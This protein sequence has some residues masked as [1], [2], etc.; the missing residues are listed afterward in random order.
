MDILYEWLRS[1]GTLWTSPFYYL[2]L[3]YIALHVRKQT[4]IERKLF[5]VKLHSWWSEWWRTL[6]WGA[7]VGAGVSV[8]F[9]F[10]GA[11]LTVPTLVML[12]VLAVLLS[13]FRV[14]YFCFAYAAG[15]LGLLQVA[16]GGLDGA[17][18]PEGVAMFARELDA[19]HMPSVLALVGVLH[20]AEAALVYK[21][22]GRLATPLFFEGKRGKTVG[23]YQ[24]QGFWPVPM[25]L[26][27]PLA[28]GAGIDGAL[29]WPTLFGGDAFAS[30][31]GA[32]AF[33]VLVGFHSLST[34]RLPQEKARVSAWR[35][36]VYGTA[37]TGLGVC[38]Y[39]VPTWWAA[40]LSALLCFG[41]HELIVALDRR[42]EALAA[43]YFVHDGRGLKVLAVV[44]GSPAAELGIEPGHVLRKV[45]GIPVR[46]RAELHAAM[47]MNAAFTKLEVAN[48]DGES[49]FL[50]RALYANE[51]HQLGIVLCPD[52]HALYVVEFEEGGL[53]SFLR[54]R[55]S[56]NGGL[57]AGTAALDRLALPAPVSSEPTV[58]M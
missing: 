46:D 21:M 24:L 52:E 35:L 3:L 13:L 11:T 26:L 12:W 28:A 7:L 51:H 45:N 58:R 53:F 38:V 1:F 14:R 43:P 34:T 4:A 2:A 22:A 30:G 6:F 8:V 32:L 31:W 15:V 18:L 47:R 25:L 44:P 54:S 57:D 23:G 27:T 50:Q 17:S 41:L 39:F 40:A 33:P 36:A 19:V 42:S 55:R 37:V 49:R 9:L 10:L 16:A 56:R 29:P 48:R 20:L 5:S